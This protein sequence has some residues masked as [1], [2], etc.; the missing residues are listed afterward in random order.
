MVKRPIG[1]TS[2]FSQRPV[3]V[4]GG[5]GFIGSHL[6]EA[7]HK[8]GEIVLVV[9]DLSHGNK[10]WLPSGVL[11]EKKDLKKSNL[12]FNILLSHKPKVIYH[13]AG[14]TQLREAILHPAADA[15][16]N[17]GTTL[18]LIE[19]CQQLP[20]EAKPQHILFASSSAVYGG[21][22]TTPFTEE[23]VTQ[24][25]TPYG[26]AKLASELYLQWYGE[27]AGIPITNFRFANVYG[28]RQSTVGEA[29]VVATFI[30][31][32]LHGEQMRVFGDGTHTRDYIFVDDVVEANILAMEQSVAGTFV[33][34]TGLS[35]STLELGKQLVNIAGKPGSIQH[36]PFSLAEQP[37]SLLDAIAFI[38]RTGWRPRTQLRQG[39]QKTFSWYQ[40]HAT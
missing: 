7:L 13:F 40:D 31:C 23:T 19:A 26:I 24:P 8:K 20:S 39:L 5:A 35:T 33:L 32:L 6:V 4:T 25:V 36:L 9:D 18:S 30:N 2:H 34:G 14:H 28:P 17:L 12:L 21:A 10:E 15:D 37:H 3:M 38:K 1:N 16:E 29:G 27:H 11:F 22:S